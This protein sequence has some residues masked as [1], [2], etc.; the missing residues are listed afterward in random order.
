M[1]MLNAFFG[2]MGKSVA[3]ITIPSTWGTDTGVSPLVSAIKTFT[4]PASNPGV[5]RFQ[6]TVNTSSAQY[7]KNGGANTAFVDGGTLAMANGD[8]LQFRTLGASADALGV[9]VYDNSNGI[10]IGSWLGTIS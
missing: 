9:A 6:I 2:V 4:V 5:I 8:T 7:K 1:S 10:L 3:P